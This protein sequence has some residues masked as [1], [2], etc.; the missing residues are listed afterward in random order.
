MNNN[1]YF[2]G[3]A[4]QLIENGAKPAIE[5]D[6]APFSKL[7]MLE[8]WV[9]LLQNDVG[10][11]NPKAIF[12]L[13]DTQSLFPLVQ[14]TVP[15]AIRCVLEATD[16]EDAIRNAISLGGDSD[17]LACIAGG[18]AEPLFGVPQNI[19]AIGMN[20]LKYYFA[21]PHK[22]VMDFEKKYGNRVI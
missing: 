19:Y 18:I 14:G 12:S 1:G 21:E 6:T 3:I 15:Q 4:Q 22:L 13:M 11:L 5:S 16:Y 8:F 7:K 10:Y 17:T 9:R 20:I 2:Q